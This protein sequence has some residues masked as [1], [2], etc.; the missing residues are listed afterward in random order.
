VLA[1]EAATD[2]SGA[3][4]AREGAAAPGLP[5]LGRTSGRA[6]PLARVEPPLARKRRARGTLAG[7]P[8]RLAGSPPLRSDP[9]GTFFAAA[10]HGVRRLS[11]TRPGRKVALIFDDGP[12]PHTPAVLREL[13]RAGARATFF[14]VGREVAR[15]PADVRLVRDAGMELGSHGWSHVPMS[16]LDAPAQRREVALAAATLQGAAGLRPRLFRPPGVSWDAGTARAVSAAGELGV[17]HTIETSDWRRPGRQALVRTA[18]GVRAGGI[19]AMHD[20]GGDRSQTVAAIRPI[21]RALRRRGL[22]CVTVSELLGAPPPGASSYG[23]AELERR[24][25]ASP[26]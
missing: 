5:A 8:T 4:V 11:A 20:A 3:G 12:G 24:L 15:R 14:V 17:L 10:G 13:R 2:G 23:F 19:V 18:E 25:A 26:R 21:V 22:A 6:Q 16:G 9:A 1:A 7:L